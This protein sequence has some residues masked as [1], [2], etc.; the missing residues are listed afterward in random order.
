MAQA[1]NTKRVTATVS[2][3][4]FER[5]TFWAESKG[6][7]INQFLNDAIDLA[8]DFENRRFPMSTMEMARMDEMIDALNS[9][10]SNQRSLENMIQSFLNM[11]IRM[12]R[13]DNY[14]LN[15]QDGDLLTDEVFNS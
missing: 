15:D 13:G 1:P 12:T 11:M 3:R 9:L 8:I 2:D 14:L 10:S 5:L 7:S 6:I 4:T